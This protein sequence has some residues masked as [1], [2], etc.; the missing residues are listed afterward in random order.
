V[1]GLPI[2]HEGQELCLGCRGCSGRTPSGAFGG[3]RCAR[4]DQRK[5]RVPARVDLVR[6]SGHSRLEFRPH[7]NDRVERLILG[8]MVKA[9]TIEARLALHAGAT[10]TV[11]L[12]DRARVEFTRVGWPL[13]DVE[14]LDSAIFGREPFLEQTLPGIHE[15]PCYMRRAK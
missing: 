11:P 7:T 5:R 4:R 15:R 1:Q 8:S 12:K 10:E 2:V 3:L 14:F 9:C 13:K 6:R